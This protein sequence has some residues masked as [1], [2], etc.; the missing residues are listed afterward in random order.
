MDSAKNIDWKEKGAQRQNGKTAWAGEFSVF[1]CNLDLAYFTHMKLCYSIKKKKK[2]AM[3][4][5][6]GDQHSNPC[7]TGSL[8]CNPRKGI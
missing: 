7:S 1:I 5:E 3:T 8:W 2:K 4:F 6:S